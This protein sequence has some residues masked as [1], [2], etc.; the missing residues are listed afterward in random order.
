MTR[1]PPQGHKGRT[2]ESL[3]GQSGQDLVEYVGLI[4]VVAILIGGLIAAAPSLGRT[5]TRGVGCEIQRLLGDG[6][7]CSGSSQPPVVSRPSPSRTTNPARSSSKSHTSG[8]SEKAEEQALGSNAL[9]DACAGNGSSEGPGPGG[10]YS[11]PDSK[12]CKTQLGKLTSRARSN[13]E[14]LAAAFQAEHY[15]RPGRES[16]SRLTTC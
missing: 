10:A 1:E 6:G 11:A 3:A 15:W 2:R 7:G 13:L 8:V 12:T 14:L 9:I 5:V 4:A 16:K